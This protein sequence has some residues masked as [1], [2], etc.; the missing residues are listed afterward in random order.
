MLRRLWPSPRSTSGDFPKG[1]DPETIRVHEWAWP[2]G[3]QSTMKNEEWGRGTEWN[4]RHQPLQDGIALYEELK[5]LVMCHCREHGPL[6]GQP[7]TSK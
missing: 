6:N 5:L 4:C 1:N 7:A 3:H 2:V